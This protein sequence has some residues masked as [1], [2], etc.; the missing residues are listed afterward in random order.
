MLVWVL[1]RLTLPSTTQGLRLF[2]F[3]LFVF[4]AVAAAADAVFAVVALSV[5]LGVSTTCRE[6]VDDAEAFVLTCESCCSLHLDS[7]ITV[8]SAQPIISGF[9]STWL[10]SP[11]LERYI[12]I[13][14]LPSDFG[15]SG[16]VD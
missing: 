7:A 1:R 12:A 9:Q 10:V 4:E 2:V 16:T 6:A 3:A 14:A 15:N 13:G 11:M 5:A 8:L